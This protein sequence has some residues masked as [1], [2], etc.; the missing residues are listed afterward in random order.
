MQ[1][2]ER[3]VSRKGRKATSLLVRAV[4]VP[5]TPPQPLLAPPLLEPPLFLSTG[6]PL[7]GGFVLFT[8]RWPCPAPGAERGF[9]SRGKLDGHLPS[10]VLS[11]QVSNTCTASLSAGAPL[12]GGNPVFKGIHK[13]SLH[14]VNYWAD[15]DRLLGSCLDPAVTSLDLTWLGSKLST[16]LLWDTHEKG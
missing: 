16:A 14:V 11:I 8:P 5:K 10:W 6:L 3:G 13:T 9:S 12:R 15:W 4:C 1:T 7:P 2:V